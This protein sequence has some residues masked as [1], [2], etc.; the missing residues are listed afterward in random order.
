VPKLLDKNAFC[1]AEVIT[2]RDPPIRWQCWLACCQVWRK[3]DYFVTS[4]YILQFAWYLEYNW[5]YTHHC[6]ADKLIVWKR[7][8]SLI[9]EDH[10]FLIFMIMKLLLHQPTLMKLKFSKMKG[11]GVT[12]K[13][14]VCWYIHVQYNKIDALRDFFI[15]S[16]VSVLQC[17]IRPIR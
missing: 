13:N 16:F 15:M 10:Q 17:T 12:M 1:A 8:C 2:G 5:S 11:E 3:I 7:E 9:L 6:L 14:A 4:K